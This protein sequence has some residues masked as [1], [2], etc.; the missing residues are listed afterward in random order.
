MDREC[1]LPS[2]GALDHEAGEFWV[3]N[4]F[5]IPA[6][7]GNLSA[8][9]RNRLFLNTGGLDFLDASFASGCDIDSDSRSVIPADFDGDG[10]IDLLVGSAGGGSLRLFQNAFPREH[11]RIL[12]ELE[13]SASNRAA[14]GS[15]VTLT[16]AGRTIVR[17]LF[18][19]NG[20]AGQ[21]PRQ[22][23]IGVGAEPLI[24]RLQIR[25]PTGKMQTF[26]SIKTDEVL[27]LREGSDKMETRPYP[28]NRPAP[29]K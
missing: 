25:W 11:R 22:W 1:S 4:P 17:D 28:Q 16:L 3:E 21:S 8:Y 18:P 24:D 15:R 12:L 29:L 23:I 2:L 10:W 14:I 26:D 19:G 5:Q 9:E 13:G 27:V 20:F 6:S 7:G